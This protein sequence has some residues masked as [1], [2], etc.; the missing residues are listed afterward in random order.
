MTSLA[1]VF[2]DFRHQVRARSPGQSLPFLS[3]RAQH[4]PPL[5]CSGHSKIVTSAEFSPDGQ[6][7]VTSSYDGT[8]RVWDAA[9][10]RQLTALSHPGAVYTA[11]FSPDGHRVL[12]AA[13][14]RTARI[15]DVDVPA[16]EIQIGW[17]KAAQ[18]DPLPHAEISARVG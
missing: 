3:S 8:A 12:T 11:T 1:A 16:I 13:D 7:V 4:R 5:V 9:T 10:G 2:E 14:D 6:Q 17:A 18:F 15:W